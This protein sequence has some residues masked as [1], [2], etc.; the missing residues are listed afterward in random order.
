[1]FFGHCKG[2]KLHYIE[3]LPTIPI[4]IL[5]NLFSKRILTT[6]SNAFLKYMKLRKVDIPRDFLFLHTV[7]IVNI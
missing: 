4:S 5:D 3:M 2:R 7:I 1:M 6:E